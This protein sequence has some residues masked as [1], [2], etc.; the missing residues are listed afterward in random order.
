M[1]FYVANMGR[2]DR[3]Y[4]NLLYLDFYPRP[5]HFLMPDEASRYRSLLGSVLSVCT[6]LAIGSYASFKLNRLVNL[7]DY[8]VNIVNED[9]YYDSDFTLS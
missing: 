3:F 2:C 1:T 8:S 7:I 4:K 9:H 6:V 5:F